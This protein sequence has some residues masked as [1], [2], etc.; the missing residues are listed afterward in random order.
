VEALVAVVVAVS[1]LGASRGAIAELELN[2]V[3]VAPSGAV[4]VDAL[5]VRGQSRS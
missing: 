3:R 4:A 5:I 2:P 1:E